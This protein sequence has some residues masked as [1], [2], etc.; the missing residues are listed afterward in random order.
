MFIHWKSQTQWHCHKRLQIG[1]GTCILKRRWN[2]TYLRSGLMDIMAKSVKNDKVQ[3]SHHG[4]CKLN[5]KNVSLKLSEDSVI[6]TL[7]HNARLGTDKNKPQEFLRG[8]FTPSSTHRVSSKLSHGNKLS[9]LQW[10]G[11]LL[12][13]HHCRLQL[14]TIPRR[15]AH[16]H[17]FPRR[18]NWNPLST[19]F[20]IHQFSGE[21][22]TEM[23]GF[24]EHKQSYAVQHKE[25]K[26]P[27]RTKQH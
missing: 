11:C 2:F 3:W 12:S 6:M 9:P 10:H 16:T 19:G 14:R 1:A 20:T 23:A 8:S 27:G 13:L 24:Q 25:S 5:L 26:E 22:A 7:S 4:D 21:P 17:T 18:E 15:A